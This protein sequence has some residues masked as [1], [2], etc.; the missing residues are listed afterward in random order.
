[1]LPPR[2]PNSGVEGRSAEEEFFKQCERQLD[3]DWI[4]IYEVHFHGQRKLTGNVPTI[5]EIDFLLLH[6]K[7][8]I[9]VVEVK[10]GK[11]ISVEDGSWY[12]TP[13]GSVD[14]K[15]IK[16]PFIQ[17]ADG[18]TNI[19]TYF[20]N[21]MQKIVWKN[22]SIK[23][24]VVF[25]GH[26]QNGPMSLN[27]KRELICDK[28][29][30]TELE[31]TLNKVANHFGVATNFSPQEI[32]QIR[33]TLKPSFELFGS[34]NQEFIKANDDLDLLTEQQLEI[35]NG[36]YE[37]KRV[38]V[39]GGAGT[40]KTILAFNRARELS[41]FGQKVLLIC[42]NVALARHLMEWRDSFLDSN[43]KMFQIS[44]ASNF[45]ITQAKKSKKYPNYKGKDER[46]EAFVD[47]LT[48]EMSIDALIVDEAQS[49]SLEDIELIDYLMNADT[50]VAIFG[51]LNQ[52]LQFFKND[53]SALDYLKKPTKFL[54]SFNCRN[55][56]EIA[57]F[58][59]YYTREP[60][61]THKGAS[62]PRPKVL[63]KKKEEIVQGAAE[64][65]LRLANEYSLNSSQIKLLGFGNY[66][67]KF[68]DWFSINPL[69]ENVVHGAKMR[70]PNYQ[71]IEY[72][73][74]LEADATIVV[75]SEEDISSQVNF[76]D[77]KRYQ[78]RLANRIQ[79]DIDDFEEQCKQFADYKKSRE[80]EIEKFQQNLSDENFLRENFGDSFPERDLNHLVKDFRVSINKSFVPMW[81]SPNMQGKWN[82][83]RRETLRVNL[84]SIVTRA[85]VALSIVTEPS[86]ES[87]I[88]QRFARNPDIDIDSIAQFETD[89]DDVD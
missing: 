44:T 37:N 22:G 60:N 58:A 50:S 4:V 33:E 40:G 28:N 17:S 73:Q 67:S 8:G 79:M 63:K 23:Q 30:L 75:L 19:H 80:P 29:D 39:T 18:V 64:E 56:K 13:H 43:S 46:K 54:L 9:F 85:K 57:D 76:D 20:K 71:K 69:P 89:T 88:K 48:D 24:L 31:K 15:L 5:G 68:R 35:M 41:G 42:S 78:K 38:L 34:S 66:S 12:T 84:Y 87:L 53:K 62:G 52:K 10:G 2:F 70:I 55:T 14:K 7:R 77:F 74:G 83:L 49:I 27:G 26:I 25:P 16:D 21:K 47:S 45:I 72:F 11:K 3:D 65:F 36:L 1:M 82:E 61:T 32:K 86:C 81:H 59:N 51:D 6:P